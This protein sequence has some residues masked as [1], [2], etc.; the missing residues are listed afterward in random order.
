MKLKSTL[1]MAAFGLL[2][3]L[4]VQAA[5]IKISSLPFNITAPGTYVLTGNLTS[6]ISSSGL[7]SINISPAIVGS[8]VVDLSGFTITGPGPWQSGGITIGV[9]VGVSGTV[10]PNTNLITIRHGVI[11]NFGTGVECLAVSNIAVNNIAF[12]LPTTVDVIG[13]SG[14]SFYNTAS[15]TV[16]NCV[17]NLN[18]TTNGVTY[19]ITDHLSAGGNSYNNDTFVNVLYPFLFEQAATSSLVLNRCQFAEPPTD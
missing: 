2:S 11:K 4:T 6:P 13:I 1:V 7:G 16:S 12:N 5:N 8:V 14:V 18:G 19:G 17:F 15:S 3:A 9:L 10:I